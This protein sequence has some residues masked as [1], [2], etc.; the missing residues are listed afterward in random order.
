MIPIIILLAGCILFLF[1]LLMYAAHFY[2]ELVEIK[3]Q[4]NSFLV[5]LKKLNLNLVLEECEHEKI[6][7]Q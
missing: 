5:E 3:N 2:T 1:F 6:N 7:R 4:L